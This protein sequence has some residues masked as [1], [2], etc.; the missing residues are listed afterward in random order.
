MIFSVIYYPLLANSILCYRSI[1]DIKL[2][3]GFNMNYSAIGYH[4]IVDEMIDGSLK[5]LRRTYTPT[6]FKPQLVG[7]TRIKR[8]VE[9]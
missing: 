6:K 5:I 7:I 4:I 2:T 9:Q 3:S 8:P 1:G